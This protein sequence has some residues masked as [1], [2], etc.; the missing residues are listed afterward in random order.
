MTFVY[1]VS[2]GFQFQSSLHHQPNISRNKYASLLAMQLDCLGNFQSQVITNTYTFI[3]LFFLH[4]FFAM[5]MVAQD[6]N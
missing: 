2:T 5:Y 6:T 1:D 3:Y 4:D